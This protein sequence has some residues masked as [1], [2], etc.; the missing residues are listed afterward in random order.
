MH[1]EHLSAQVCRRLR[2]EVRVFWIAT[3]KNQARGNEQC[4]AASVFVLHAN[5]P[6]LTP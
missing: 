3:E 2:D 6:T 5:E 4:R 1:L